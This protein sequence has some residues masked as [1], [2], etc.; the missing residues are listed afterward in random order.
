MRR[1]I[2]NIGIMAH[3]DAG[4]TTLT[5]RILFNTGQLHTIGEVHKGTAEMDWR[6]IEKKHGITISAAATSCNWK[7]HTVTIIDTPGHVDFTIE[8]ERS[9]RVLDS[10]IAVFS[11]VSGVEPQTE[12]VWR[13]ANK[14]KIPRICFINKM[15]CIG[16]DFFRSVEM[17]REQLSANPLVLQLPMG[18]ENSFNGIIDL[19]TMSAFIWKQDSNVPMEIAVPSEFLN[20]AHLYRKKLIEQLVEIDNNAMEIYLDDENNL[21]E[22]DLLNLVRKGCIEQFFTPVLC[23]SAFRNIG[24][25]T[26][27]DAVVNYCPA[28]NDCPAIEGLDCLSGD[29][30]K[31]TSSES[32]PLIALAFKVQ[33]SRFGALT[34][35]RL[36][37]GKIVKGMSIAN[38]TKGQKERIS[39]IVQMHANDQI[40][41]QDAVAGDIV[42]VTGLK[43]TSS[44]DTLSDQSNQVIL[45]GLKPPEPVIEAVIEP[46]SAIDQEKMSLALSQIAKEDPSLRISSDTETGQTL[47]RG[48]GE[49][50]LEILVESLL[51]EHDVNVSIGQP[52][53]AYREAIT[54]RSEIVYTHRKQDGGAGQFANIK[55][56]FEPIAEGKSG[57]VFENK[58]VGGAIPKEYIPSIEK[59]LKQSLQEGV[60]ASYPMLGLRATLIDGSYHKQDSSGLAFEL[61][62]RKAYQL[63][64][65][66]AN[67]TLL[68]PVMKVE[69]N[70]PSEYL[71]SIIGD[72]NARRGVI[73]ET[74]VQANGHDIIAYVPLSN[75]FGY[76]N[77][78]RTLSRGRATFTMQF[79]QYSVM[80]KNIVDDVLA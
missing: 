75:M 1:H 46:N 44:G 32:G 61:A 70:T 69:V 51:D 25:Q 14:F 24:I 13:Q 52:R 42:A 67:P 47:V 8:V 38:T 71:G 62:A 28:P 4:K 33:M 80:P 15:D 50:H 26:L 74:Q 73:C 27:L 30:I 77:R 40:E 9:L 18:F 2:R 56:V 49:L 6:D 21:K 31:L 45:P 60:L 3:I 20:D 34:F 53:V 72:M 39:R 64:V 48:M 11:A 19:L 78:L 58:I 41:V 65:A 22:S 43:I 66:K 16:A 36:Y 12:T 59:A 54:E 55:I 68:E 29:V 76:V 5:E 35:I 23:G 10:A 63:G 79:N 7:D 17:I 37:T 57:L